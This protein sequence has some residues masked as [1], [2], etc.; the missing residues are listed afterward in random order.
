MN[1]VDK[2]VYLLFGLTVAQVATVWLVFYI[3]RVMLDALP[4]VQEVQNHF[5]K[6]F[7]RLLHGLA[8]NTNIAVRGKGR[9]DP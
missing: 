2:A 8:G 1:P 5:W 3:F 9:L 6:F 7:I 4:T